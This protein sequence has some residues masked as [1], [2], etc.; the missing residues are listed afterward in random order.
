MEDPMRRPSY[1][2]SAVLAVSL[3]AAYVPQAHAASAVKEW[4]VLNFI[5]GKNNLDS[6]GAMNINQMEEVGSTDKINM[7]V[8]WGSLEGPSVKR[9]LVV[10]DNDTGK[11]TSPIV[12]DLGNA[13]MGDWQH[14]VDFV[15]W[16]VKNYPAQKYMINV[17]DHGSGWHERQQRGMLS[18]FDISWDEDSGNHITTVQLGQAMEEAARAIGHKV[19]V[20]GS[21][22]CLMAMAEI[23]SEMAD[24]VQ[25]FVGSQDLEPGAG[26]PYGDWMR[27]WVKESSS[28]PQL[29]GKLLVDAYLKSYS[30][31]SNGDEEVTLSAFDLAHTDA[32]HAAVT[33]LR[34][35]IAGL[36]A[37]D[38]GKVLKVAQKT[39]NFYTSDYSDLIHFTELL[40]REGITGLQPSISSA[41]HDVATQYVTANGVTQSFKDAKGLSF[42]FPTDKYTLDD[43]LA[44]YK[45]LKFDRATG[46]SEALAKVLK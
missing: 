46:W 10:K 1:L 32:L 7:V 21:D 9:L 25:V 31:G 6:Y 16:G 22:A 17:W 38:A 37:A 41:L 39:Q 26:W 45:T 40:P 44:L 13:D 42:W 8:E 19:D 20:Y 28:T 5:N 3:I 36:A 43:F 33:N 27:A 18:P 4:T 2:L 34:K 24:S 35:G 12:Q 23:A 30:G 14:L 29:V 15:K 11:V